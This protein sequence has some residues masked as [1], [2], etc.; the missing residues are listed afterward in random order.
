MSSQQ[1][2]PSGEVKLELR[3]K[4]QQALFEQINKLY[5]TLAETF[6]QEQ[7]AIFTASTDKVSRPE[8]SNLKFKGEFK[9]N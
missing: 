4:E 8:F 2:N 9:I 1:K 3:S 7:A 5:A 6:T